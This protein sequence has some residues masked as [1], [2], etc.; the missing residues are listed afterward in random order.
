VLSR[1]AI[2]EALFRSLGAADRAESRALG[3]ASYAVLYAVARAILQESGLI[4]ES[5]FRTGTS[6]SELASLAAGR[7]AVQIQCTAARDVIVCRIQTREGRH[8]LHYDHEALSEVLEAVDRGRH[9]PLILE[10]PCLVVDTSAGYV[11]E[12]DEIVAFCRRSLP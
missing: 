1:D 11:P 7:A 8:P 4:L 6:E 2:K 10:M 9:E 12:L 3:P 5:N